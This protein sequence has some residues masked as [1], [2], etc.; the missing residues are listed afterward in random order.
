MPWYRGPHKKPNIEVIE[1]PTYE[2]IHYNYIQFHGQGPSLPTDIPLSAHSLKQL[3]KLISTCNIPHHSTR[4]QQWLKG[5]ALSSSLTSNPKTYCS[6][7]TI[8]LSWH[9]WR[10]TGIGFPRCKIVSSACHTRGFSPPG[11]GSEEGER[12]GVNV[13]VIGAGLVRWRNW[14]HILSLSSAGREGKGSKV[15]GSGGEDIAAESWGWNAIWIYV[16]DTQSVPAR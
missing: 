10:I 9:T 3:L 5:N 13:I 12:R 1:V 14:A 15:C 8:R 7:P 6:R 11:G 2:R 16:I 4:F